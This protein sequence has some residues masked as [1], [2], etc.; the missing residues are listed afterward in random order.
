MTNY[1]ARATSGCGFK[2]GTYGSWLPLGGSTQSWGVDLQGA[3]KTAQ[4]TITIEISAIAN[5]SVILDTA[6]IE[7]DLATEF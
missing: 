5:P 1:Q 4:C 7:L 3:N 6:T 2:F